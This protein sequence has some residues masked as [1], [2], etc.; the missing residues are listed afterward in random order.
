MIGWIEVKPG[1]EMPQDG[2]IV[3]ISDGDDWT[4]ACHWFGKFH[5]VDSEGYAG[6]SDEIG[7]V[8]HWARPAL[9]RAN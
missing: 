7:G 8:T 2:E 4:H 9:P 1:C 6:M 5:P 3:L